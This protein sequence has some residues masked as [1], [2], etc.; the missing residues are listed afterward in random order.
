M[1]FYRFPSLRKASALL[2]GMRYY[3]GT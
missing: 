1:D 2:P 3:A